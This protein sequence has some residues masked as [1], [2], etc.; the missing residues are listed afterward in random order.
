[1]TDTLTLDRDS[2][3]RTI[4]DADQPVLVD[5]WAGWCGQCRAIAP[6]VDA[7]ATEFRGRA[8]VAKL[9]VDAHPEI[10]GDHGVRSIPTLIVFRNGT[11][12]DRIVGA[13]Q[14]AEL[15]QRLSRAVE[16]AASPGE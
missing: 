16:T 10:A 9:D 7:L 13:V 6:A 1:M 2:F 14:P 8:V 11:E 12:V 15:R 4:H 3:D 5:F